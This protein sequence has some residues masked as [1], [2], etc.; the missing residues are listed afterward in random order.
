M[1][2]VHFHITADGVDLVDPEDVRAFH[3]VRAPGLTDAEFAAATRGA[4]LGEPL[5]GGTHLMV[6]VETIRALAAGRVGPTWADDLA[7][8]IAYATRKGWTDESGSR[9]RAHVEQAG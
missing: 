9:I 4:G 8:M 3:A 5:P 2:A 7:G 1:S 6:P